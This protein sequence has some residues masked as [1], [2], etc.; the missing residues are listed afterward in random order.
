MS[1]ICLFHSLF[2]Y[3][4]WH[5]TVIPI[6]AL[7]WNPEEVAVRRLAFLS[8]LFLYWIINLK[9]IKFIHQ[10]PSDIIVIIDYRSHQSSSEFTY[11]PFYYSSASPDF[12]LSSSFSSSYFFSYSFFSPFSS[13]GSFQSLGL[14]LPL[15]AKY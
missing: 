12:A 15:R 7:C 9:V 1:S 4:F 8:F 6:P 10:K 5:P 11:E 3:L 13:L 14:G 2:S